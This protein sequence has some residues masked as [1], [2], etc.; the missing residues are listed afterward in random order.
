MFNGLFLNVIAPF[1]NAYCVAVQPSLKKFY[2]TNTA[3]TKPDTDCV[4]WGFRHEVAE[5][6]A[7]L[8]YYAASSGNFLG[9]KLPL[10]AA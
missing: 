8:G 10:L 3:L 5:N 6:W 4:I 1:Y 2:K 9:K 7:I